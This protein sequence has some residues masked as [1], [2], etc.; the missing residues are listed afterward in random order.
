M[1][2]LVVSLILSFF[3]RVLSRISLGY[4]IKGYGDGLVYI[5]VLVY[6]FRFFLGVLE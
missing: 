5:G 4:R 2:G 1:R 6:S 3:F